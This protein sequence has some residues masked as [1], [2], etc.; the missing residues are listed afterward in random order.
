MTNFRSL[1]GISALFA[2]ASCNAFKQKVNVGPG[3]GTVQ[4]HTFEIL[5]MLGGA[6]LLGLWLGWILWSRYKEMVDS[7]RLENESLTATANALRT[8]AETLRAKLAALEADKAD[9]QA[10]ASDLDHEN[11]DLKSRLV[12]VEGDLARLMERNKA[13]ETELGLAAAH[14]GSV[15]EVPV[16]IVE[17]VAPLEP[18]TLDLE[19][20]VA[21]DA[22]PVEPEPAPLD[23]AESEP[24]AMPVAEIPAA[25]TLVASAFVGDEGLVPVDVPEPVLELVPIPVNTDSEPTPATADE[26]EGLLMNL[27]DAATPLAATS[28]VRDNLRIVEGIGP[29][30]EE[31]L[32]NEG[33][34]TYADLAAT[35]VERIKEILAAAG[36]R[37]AMHDPGTWPAQA[38]LAANGEWDNLKAYQG[39]LN[40]GKRP[41]G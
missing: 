25:E 29:K 39:F 9:W 27:A 1:L 35:S 20:I 26:T 7:L 41:G 31:L 34:K 10:R 37:Y 32:F 38:L 18:E 3:T 4:D 33:I 17:T 12:A 13:L 6:F 16:E 24:A 40:A 36:S 23:V 28:D 14:S 22:A 8:E 19:P 21:I 30:I 5:V 15:A 11:I 2:L